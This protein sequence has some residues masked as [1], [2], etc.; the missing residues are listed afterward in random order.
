MGI[1]LLI[2]HI[3][4]CIAVYILMRLSVL[5]AARMIMPLVVLGIWMSAAAGD[6]HQRKAGDP[7]RGG[8]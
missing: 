7:C 6:P 8:N 3:I 1:F 5:K 4:L 2:I